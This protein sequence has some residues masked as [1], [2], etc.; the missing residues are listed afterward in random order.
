MEAGPV[1]RGGAVAL[2][3]ECEEEASLTGQERVFPAG[4]R[5]PAREIETERRTIE[6]RGPFEVGDVEA[7]VADFEPDGGG[8]HA[9]LLGAAVVSPSNHTIDGKNDDLT[10]QAFLW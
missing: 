8:G 10:C 6:A 1:G 9:L 7:D 4:G 5:A 2:A 3:P